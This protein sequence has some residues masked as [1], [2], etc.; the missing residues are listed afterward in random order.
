MKILNRYILKEHI[1]PF[2]MALVVIMFILLMNFLVKYIG[3]IFGKGLPIL[4]IVRLIALNLA[5]MLALAVPMATLVAVLMAYGRLSADN[6]ITILKS[7]GISIYKIIRPSLYLGL[8]LT[9]LM[10]YFNDRILPESNHQ[11]KLVFRAVKE[12]K[13]TLQLEEHIFFTLH[14]YTILVEQIEK[15]LPREWLG[16]DKMLG[17]EYSDRETIDRLRYLTLFD[18]SNPAQMV[19]ITASEGYMVYSRER[20]SLIFTLFNGEFHELDQ[21]KVEEYQRSE[22]KKHVVY[23]PA[24]EF[25]FEEQQ[26]S[27]RGDREMNISMMQNKIDQFRKQIATQQ[28]RVQSGLNSQLIR[29]DTLLK[30]LGDSTRL[31]QSD[32]ILNHIEIAG[33]NWRSA[34]SQAKRIIERHYHQMRTKHSI[35]DNH[36]ASINKYAVEIHKKFSI[37]FACIVFVLIGAPLG[38][39]SRKGG[40]G[41]A[42]SLSIGFFLLYW[43]FLIGG[44]DL[45]DRKFMTPFMAMWAPNIIVGGAGMYFIWRAVKE[46]AF[47]PWDKLGRMF[48]RK[49]D[50]QT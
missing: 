10:I 25:E 21:K 43:V 4:I 31:A 1:Q 32:S 37:P 12:K 49:K 38:V 29:I 40:M 8:F 14:D 35:I 3:Q 36:Q 2:I 5:W 48:K 9:L 6:E 30:E 20:K 15:P 16:L 18:R 28:E 13:P 27:Y 41:A 34:K 45:A 26:D 19:T 46:T 17:P 42:I 24:E 22:F 50:D 39:M 23:I 33:N 7:S 47:I 44:E 11:A